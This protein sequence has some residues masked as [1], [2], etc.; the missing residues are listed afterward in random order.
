M[1][2]DQGTGTE[3]VVFVRLL[4]E[5]T[6]VW[7]PVQATHLGGAAYALSTSPHSDDEL[8]EFEPGSHVITELR[9]LSGQ[10]SKVAVRRA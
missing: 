8:W 5:G 1:S 7:R 4:E 3:M 2:E 6:D 9:N 10:C